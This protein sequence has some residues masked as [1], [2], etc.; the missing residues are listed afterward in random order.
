MN[1]RGRSIALVLCLT[2]TV[3]SAAA[4]VY[5]SEGFYGT[6]GP[7]FWTALHPTNL[8]QSDDILLCNSMN[9]EGS[10]ETFLPILLGIV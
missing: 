7:S 10:D 2:I 9:G 5:T 3:L 6:A 1:E 8:Q 4:F